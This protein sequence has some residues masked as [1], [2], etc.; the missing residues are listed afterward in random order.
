[1]KRRYR[2]LAAAMAAAFC[3]AVVAQ[4]QTACAGDVNLDDAKTVVLSCAMT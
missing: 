2:F 1:M 4:T 3:L